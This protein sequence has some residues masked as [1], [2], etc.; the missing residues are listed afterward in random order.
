MLPPEHRLVSVSQ[1]FQSRTDLT[2][3]PTRKEK[4]TLL[5]P[6]FEQSHT[7]R[8]LPPE[9]S[10]PPACFLTGAPSPRSASFPGVLVPDLL[11]PPAQPTARLPGLPLPAGSAWCWEGRAAAGQIPGCTASIWTPA[12]STC[13]LFSSS[14]RHQTNH[15]STM[16][17]HLVF[18]TS[19]QKMPQHLYSLPPPAWSALTP[20][21]CDHVIITSM[22]R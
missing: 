10:P 7:R 1:S 11:P 19:P 9:V 21:T 13:P 3:I 15:G 17:R 18:P 6:R 8:S 2:R 20:P 12:T 16:Q 14:R 22:F 5:L 4:S